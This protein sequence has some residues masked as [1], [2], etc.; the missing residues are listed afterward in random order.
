MESFHSH[1]KLLLTGE[2]LVLLG[3]LA[4]AVPTGKGQK[5]QVSTPATPKEGLN[6]VSKTHDGKVWLEVHF[7]QDFEPSRSGREIQVLQN[8][9]QTA[10]EMA[11]YSIPDSGLVIESGLEFPRNWGLGSSSTLVLNIAKWLEI[12]PFVLQFK[13]FGGSAYDIACGLKESPI[14]Y[15]LK[16]GKPQTEMV[17]FNPPFKDK[18][19]FVHLGK[20]QDSRAAIRDFMQNGSDKHE[21]IEKITALTVKV[22]NSDKLNEFEELIEKHEFLMAEVLNT[23]PIQ[24]LYFADYPGHIKSLGA[25]GGDFILATGSDE[26]QMYFM[27]RGYTTILSYPEMV[28]S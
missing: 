18:L 21:E 20:K 5:M 23:K 24:Q 12:D 6:W 13:I 27:E 1:G 19:F 2:Y 10:F 7:N 15:Q 3:A 14:H 9:L 8:L 17:S 22:T 11:E 25:W 26:E 4:L 16:N 28:K